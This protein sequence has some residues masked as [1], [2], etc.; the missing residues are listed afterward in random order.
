MR[1][2]QVRNVFA[3]ESATSIS[4]QGYVGGHS[5]R[6]AG[7]TV[8]LGQSAWIASAATGLTHRAG[9]HDAAHTRANGYQKSTLT[10][11][12]TNGYGAGTSERYNGGDQQLGQSV[13]IASGATGETKRV[14]FFD[15]AHTSPGLPLNPAGEQYSELV[16]LNSLGHAAGVSLRYDAGRGRSAWASDF[17]TGA[18]TRIGILDAAHTASDGGQ[19]SA[20]SG[21]NESDLVWGDSTRYAGS[22]SVGKTAWIYNI[23]TTAL[24]EFELSVRA[25]DGYAFSQIDAVNS[26]GL[27][28]GHYTYFDAVTSADLGLRPFLW[29]EELGLVDLSATIVASGG[30]IFSY[31]FP[32]QSQLLDSGWVVLAGV[33]GGFEYGQINYALDFSAVPEPSSAALLLGACAISAAA[34]RRRRVRS[35]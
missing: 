30:E 23:A 24:T 6:Y 29:S 22:V 13:W 3:Y 18:T 33:P 27:A 2:S 17:A 8:Q 20:V 10:H 35:N 5:N 32:A 15:A 25:N 19:T 16:A 34:L 7:G 9:L 28:L 31:Y 4:E 12:T 26:S 14:G 21:L 1:T 11:L